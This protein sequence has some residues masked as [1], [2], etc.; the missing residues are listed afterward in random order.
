MYSQTIVIGHVGADPELRYTPSGVPVAT[1]SLADSR[2]WTGEDGKSH[3]ETTWFRVTCWKKLAE[4][5]AKFVVKGGSVHVVGRVK[6]KA[7]LDKNTNEP[8]ASLELTA[9]TVTFLSKAADS[10]TS[11]ASAP[12]HEVT[13]ED[14]P[15]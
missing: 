15:F 6:A 8:R 7:W 14:I 2:K 13:P 3:E 12:V 9:D 10:A 4:N 11:P 1:F 5:V